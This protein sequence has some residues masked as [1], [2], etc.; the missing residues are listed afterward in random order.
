MKFYSET[1]RLILRGFEDRDIEP[2]SEYRS[3]PE[4]ARCQ[5]WDTPFDRERAAEFVAAMRG[6]TPG[7][8]GVWYQVALELKETHR[9]IGDV[10]FETF[11][12]YGSPLQAEIAFTLAREYQGLGYAFEAVSCLLEY[13]F[14][15]LKVHRVRANIDPNNRASARLL[16]RL[17]LRLEGHFIK[18]LWY[19]GRWADEDWFAILDLEWEARKKR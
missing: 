17:G 13:L 2:F 18:S 4:V 8:A 19:K 3:D 12:D 6:R 14:E 9:L 1:G 16:E 11:Q 5:G 7:V 15:G 10:A